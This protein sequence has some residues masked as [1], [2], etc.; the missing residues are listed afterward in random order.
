MLCYVLLCYVI[1]L[2]YITL[3]YISTCEVHLAGK[4]SDPKAICFWGLVIN[5]I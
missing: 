3:H 5:L 2:H 1:T 4:L